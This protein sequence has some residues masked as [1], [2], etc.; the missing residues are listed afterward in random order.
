MSESLTIAEALRNAAQRLRASGVADAQLVAQSML[1]EALGCDRTHLIVNFQQPVPDDALDVCERML[2]RRE[3]GEPLQYI[4]GRQEFFGLEFEVTS[5]VLIPR[6]ETELIVEEVVRLSAG[7]ACPVIA[8]IGTGSGC[9]AVTLARELPQAM[10]TASDISPAAI[11]IA[12]RN[13]ERHKLAD[14]IQFIVG[15]L[16]EPLPPAQQF[17][18]IAS[19]PP[20]VRADEIE[21]LQREV[22]DWEPRLALTDNADGLTF[23]RRLFD[24]APARLKAGGYLLC[25]MGYE[26]SEKV[27]TLVDETLWES[28]QMPVDL[29]GIPRTIVLRKKKQQR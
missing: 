19:N 10:V 20:Y 3:A 4:L 27:C 2:R 24:E 18:F 8:D 25:E 29:Q 15:D 17:D 23:F 22:R 11:A 16:L 21:G 14:R 7:I 6:P 1:A 9:I 5:D 28:P 26:Q 12:R 13:A